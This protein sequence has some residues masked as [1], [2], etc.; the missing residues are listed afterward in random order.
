M[1]AKTGYVWFL[2]VYVSMKVN[3]MGLASINGSCSELEIRSA[4]D[5]HFALSYAS[6]GNDS[7]VIVG[8]QTVMEW[9]AE[10]LNKTEK[11]QTQFADYAGYT[12]D[13][14]WVYVKALQTLIKQG[15]EIN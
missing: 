12:Y 11:N 4:L 8:N 5:G 7:T 10:Y 1:T 15:K 6:F 9:K 14:I 2:P 13:A 3:A